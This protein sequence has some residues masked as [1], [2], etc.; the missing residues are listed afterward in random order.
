MGVTISLSDESEWGKL[1]DASPN[2]TIFHDLR[3]LQLAEK[4]SKTK[5]HLLSGKIG[6]ELVG[7]FPIFTRRRAGLDICLS[8]PPKTGIRYLGPIT[9]ISTDYKQNKRERTY[10]DFI[11]GCLNHID[12][13]FS[14]D[15]TLISS[16]P[17]IHDIRSFKNCGYTV[18]PLFT[19]LIDTSLES[20]ALLASFSNS[21]R[22]DI[23]K[24]DEKKL[25]FRE[26][27]EDELLFVHSLMEKRYSEQG[28]RYPIP[29]QYLKDIWGVFGGNN[30]RVFVAE[31][32][33]ILTG[34][35]TVSYGRNIL[36]WS[37]L[38]NNSTAPPEVNSWV[39]WQ[40]IL[41]AN[42]NNIHYY[43]MLGANIP[44]LYEYKLKFSPSL[45]THYT[46]TKKNL[47]GALGEYL[48]KKL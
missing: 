46:M 33:D 7:G 43:D 2:T 24:A 39:Q 11:E 1:V 5:L 44:R 40:I 6:D 45:S 25:T 47:L 16:T 13:V 36:F 15:Y 18:E 41:W 42:K 19:Y 9:S 37:G 48:Y 23:K 35:I 20:N 26:G 30:I 12:L 14:P 10:L 17:D 32:S 3:W 21:I 8:P 22:R 34:I 27:G 4:Y 31:N 28:K 29:K 38:S